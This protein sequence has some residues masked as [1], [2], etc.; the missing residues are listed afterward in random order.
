[1]PSGIGRGRAGFERGRAEGGEGAELGDDARK[2]R[3]VMTGAFCLSKAICDNVHLTHLV[4]LSSCHLVP[5]APSP[6]RP[7]IGYTIP[8]KRANEPT[9]EERMSQPKSYICDMDGVLVRGSQV[10]PGANE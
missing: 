7:C 3:C 10:V 6:L 8:D 9:K 4:I 2:R 1:M 5:F